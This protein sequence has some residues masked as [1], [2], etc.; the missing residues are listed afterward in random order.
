DR[1]ASNQKL[2]EILNLFNKEINW[3]EK[4][5]KVLL[6]QLEK[7][8]ELIRDTI[9]IRQ[10]DKLPNKQA[11]SIAQCESNHHNISLHF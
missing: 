10:Q 9:G 2:N 3:R 4:P 8:D 7:Y 6:P 1:Q 5:A 11:L